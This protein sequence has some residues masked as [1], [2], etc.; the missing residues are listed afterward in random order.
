MI[1]EQYTITE[2]RTA[3]ALQTHLLRNA[4]YHC[5]IVTDDG[6]PD[7]HEILIGNTARAAL[8]VPANGYRIEQIGTRLCV[9]ADH[10]YAYDLALEQLTG[11][12]FPRTKSDISV[13]GLSL[14]GTDPT[15]RAERAGSYR[16]SAWRLR[17]AKN[18]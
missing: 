9:A 2:Y 12:V 18:D 1:P 8:T 16:I 11:T 14:S 3:Y 6:K 17:D 15:D 4:G 7:A 13:E 5:G 10:V